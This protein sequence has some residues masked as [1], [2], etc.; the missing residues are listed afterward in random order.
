MSIR[1]AVSTSTATPTR[2]LTGGVVTITLKHLTLYKTDSTSVWHVITEQ[3]T[4]FDALRC[5]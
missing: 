3:G 1:P 2:A 4:C 5:P